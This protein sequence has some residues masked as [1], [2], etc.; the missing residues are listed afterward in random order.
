MDLVAILVNVVS[1]E[2]GMFEFWPKELNEEGDWIGDTEPGSSNFAA[3]TLE[4]KAST[5]AF[6]FNFTDVSLNKEIMLKWESNSEVEV[7]YSN[8]GLEWWTILGNRAG[9]FSLARQLC[10]LAQPHVQPNTLI[11][12]EPKCELTK[13]SLPLVLEKATFSD[14]VPWANRQY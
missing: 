4:N 14:D 12:F 8:H 2:N 5:Q 11:R 1:E 13:A 10:I 6:R 7:V 3:A 9:F